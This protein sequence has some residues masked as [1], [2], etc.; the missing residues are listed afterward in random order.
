MSSGFYEKGIEL[1]RQR[2][3]N[4]KRGAPGST[5]GMVLG[6]GVS[7]VLLLVFFLLFLHVDPFGNEKGKTGDGA[8]S[9]KL[10]VTESG[11]VSVTDRDAVMVSPASE[12]GERIDIDG[13]SAL[14]PAGW[15]EME[16]YYYAET[17]NSVAMFYYD[18]QMAGLGD[19]GEDGRVT[20]ETADE[21]FQDLA[22]GMSNN[23]NSGGK[24]RL[25][26][27]EAVEYGGRPMVRNTLE[28]TINGEGILMEIELYYHEESGNIIVFSYGQSNN[29]KQDHFP[30]YHQMLESL[31]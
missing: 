12:A 22:L 8:E 23:E 27:A 19:I 25:Y 2:G 15:F 30:E 20:E 13:L 4:K 7:F 3:R 26:T 16:G 21:F 17:G 14:M 1:M 18:T 5:W 28:S 10:S 31:K 24:V 6:A 29:C 9:G 11:N